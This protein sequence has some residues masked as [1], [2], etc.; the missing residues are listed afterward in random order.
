[1]WARVH[2][3]D[4]IRPQPDGSA[5]VFIEDERNAA[6]MARVPGLSTV[7]AIARVLNARRVLETKYNGKGEVRYSTGANPPSFL[8][9][10][11]VRAGALLVDSTGDRIKVPAA[12]AS[13]SS[14]VDHAMAELAHHTRT[15]VGAATVSA[16]LDK[17]EA[18]RRK[19]PLDKDANPAAYWTAVFELVALAGELTRAHGGMW[20]ETKEMPVPF[21]IRLANGKVA[22]PA[23]PAMR[24]V[25]GTGESMTDVEP[26]A[27]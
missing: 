5:H 19:T 27:K 4:R 6:L 23:K 8:L 18:N 26:P 22:T 21:A 20:I 10:A 7:I 17:S 16:A 15:S 13:V 25:E 24:I 12:P 1:M 9:D 3:I 2:K 14:V 11:I